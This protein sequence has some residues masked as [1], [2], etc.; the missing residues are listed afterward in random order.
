MLL[1][2]QLRG[3]LGAVDQA[4]TECKLPGLSGRLAAVLVARRKADDR[5]RL[6]LHG[7]WTAVSKPELMDF[8]FKAPGGLDFMWLAVPSELADD[9]V[10]SAPRLLGV[11]SHR[12]ARG[13]SVAREAQ[14][15]PLQ[16]ETRLTLLSTLLQTAYLWP[17]S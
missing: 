12:P 2:C 10:A 5:E 9:A 16:A 8:E 7:L 13:L 1:R 6:E 14:R 11:L 3:W 15:R 4:R 17:A